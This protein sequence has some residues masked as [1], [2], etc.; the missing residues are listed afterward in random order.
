MEFNEFQY[1]RRLQRQVYKVGFFLWGQNIPFHEEDRITTWLGL[2]SIATIAK[3][4]KNVH[5]T[6]VKVR[7][8]D[9]L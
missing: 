2:L 6:I 3:I 1:T 5:Y 7:H 8:W 4:V 9:K